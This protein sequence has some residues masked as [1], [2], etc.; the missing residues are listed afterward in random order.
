MQSACEGH[1]FKTKKPVSSDASAH[2][3]SNSGHSGWPSAGFS[4]SLFHTDMDIP[5]VEHGGF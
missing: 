1:S 2:A 3:A 4:L 5:A